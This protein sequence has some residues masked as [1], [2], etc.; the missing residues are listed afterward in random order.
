MDKD[1][2]Y[3]YATEHYSALSRKDILPFVTASMDFED[4]MLS[5]MSDRESQILYDIIWG[6]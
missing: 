5:E 3:V 4:I 6:I 1:V 2:A